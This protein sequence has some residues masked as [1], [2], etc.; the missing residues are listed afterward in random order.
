MNFYPIIDVH[1][2][3]LAFNPV[4]GCP[5]KCRYCFLNGI[6]MTHKKPIVLCSAEEAVDKLLNSPYYL[7]DF[8][9]C[10]FSQTD[11]FAT[12]D[13][14]AY[15]TKVLQIMHER[16]ILNPKIFITKCFIPI[17]FIN[18][19]EEYESCGEK[20]IFYLSYSGLENDIEIGI[21]KEKIK[22]NFINLHN[23]NQKIIHYWRPLLPQ[24][25]S[26]SKIQ[27]IIKFVKNYALASV[28]V[29]LKVQTNIIENFDF[30]PEML[31]C[32][33]KALNA[34]CIWTKEAYEILFGDNEKQIFGDY[35]IFQS[36]SCAL[37]LA[38]GITDR[39][40]FW[41]SYYCEKVNN[42]P[43]LQKQRCKEYYEKI[44]KK[45]LLEKVK[46]ILL[47][48]GYDINNL[49]IELK[50][51]FLIIE[52]IELMQ[53]DLTYLTQVTHMKIKA[54]KSKDDIYW[55]SSLANKKPVII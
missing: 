11:A 17:E 9:I 2:T 3:W 27:E 38:L 4:Q 46:D 50:E 49:K 54:N 35:P 13:N 44:D 6:G 29:G 55:N 10:F 37:A 51:N 24:N 33:E 23:H 18:L 20:F 25:S 8:P 19:C 40:A 12:P 28:I 34:E 21:N 5:N 42:C 39:N 52:N 47:K 26:V 14:I 53:R 48:I 16:K 32:K 22:Q 43:K 45:S 1:A 7:P 36:N 15:L 31:N 30:W 41:K